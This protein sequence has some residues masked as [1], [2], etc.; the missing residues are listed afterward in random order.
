MKPPD[1]E[2]MEKFLKACSSPGNIFYA[3]VGSQTNKNPYNFSLKKHSKEA[4]KKANSQRLREQEEIERRILE[5]TEVEE[6]L[7]SSPQR[8]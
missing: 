5:G 3:G 4:Q 1:R 8:S 6:W 2:Q 7:G